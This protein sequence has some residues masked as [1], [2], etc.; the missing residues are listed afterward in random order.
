MIVILFISLAQSQYHDILVGILG[1]S[2]VYHLHSTYVETSLK[3]QDIQDVGL[4]FS[5]LFLPNANLFAL[6]SILSAVPY[7]EVEFLL[8]LS[9]CMTLSSFTHLYFVF[10]IVACAIWTISTVL[11]LLLMLI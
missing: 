2:F 1:Y 9:S 8:V 10:C 7:D 5:S 11:S 6:I 4:P 3:Q